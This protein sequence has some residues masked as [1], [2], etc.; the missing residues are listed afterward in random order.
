MF[1]S[2]T[3]FR[4][5]DYS[6][7]VFCITDTD[8]TSERTAWFGNDTSDIQHMF[9]MFC[10]EYQ[11]RNLDI[12]ENL[13]LFSLVVA[14]KYAKPESMAIHL[15]VLSLQQDAY[16]PKHIENWEEIKKSRD[17]YIEKYRLLE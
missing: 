5:N 3:S 4:N 15:D 7:M 14:R 6:P 1:K 16:L 2:Y 8:F 12:G 17:K 13:A 11:K 10:E 9:R